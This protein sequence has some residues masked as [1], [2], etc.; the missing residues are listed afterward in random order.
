MA[1]IS[2]VDGSYPPFLEALETGNE[3]A[4]RKQIEELQA[5]LASLTKSLED[6]RRG[7]R[8]LVLS[9]TDLVAEILRFMNDDLHQPAALSEDDGGLVLVDGDGAPWCVCDVSTSEADGVTKQH[10]ASALVRRARAGLPDGFP[11]LVIVNTMQG[12]Q[13]LEARD[14]P[15]APEVARRA[16]EDHI[17]AVRTLDLLRVAQRAG[18]GFP[19]AEQMAEA[20]LAGGGWFEVDAALNARVRTGEEAP[21]P[22]LSRKK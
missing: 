3:A 17:M 12:T 18:N 19:G 14:R 21:V 22:P 13:T 16:A 9:G 5:Q 6:T 1:A 4:I 20:V 10:L 7:K 15:V 2:G 11:C 8:I